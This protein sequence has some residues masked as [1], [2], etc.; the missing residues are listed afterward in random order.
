MPIISSRIH[1]LLNAIGGLLGTAFWIY[2]FV[3]I[4]RV[5]EL[6]RSGF[7]W[8]AEVPLT[9]IWLFLCVPALALASSRRAAPFASGFAVAGAV[10]FGYIWPQ[11]LSELGAR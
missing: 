5:E 3:F 11:I 2:T 8:L 9:G 6:D 7:K 4:S 10:V 1:Q